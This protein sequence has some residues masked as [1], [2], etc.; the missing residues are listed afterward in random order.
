LL[1]K[2]EKAA[3]VSVLELHWFKVQNQSLKKRSKAQKLRRLQ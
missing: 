2:A 1:A 3:V